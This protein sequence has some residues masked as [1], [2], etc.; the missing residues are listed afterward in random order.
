[1]AIE[2]KKGRT[3]RGKRPRM[4]GSMVEPLVNDRTIIYLGIDVVQYDGPAV[5]RGQHYPRVTREAFLAWAER[6]VTDELPEGEY[7][8]WPP[9]K[10]EVANGD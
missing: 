2:L 3:Y 5:K 7:A 1:M 9:K 4:V 8:T 10:P 6:D